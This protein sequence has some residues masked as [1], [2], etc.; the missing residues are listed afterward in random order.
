MMGRDV[1]IGAA[2]GLI[3]F[4]ICAETQACK[5]TGLNEEQATQVDDY[6]D[7]QFLCVNKSKTLEE[8]RAC[9]CEVKARYGRPCALPQK[10]GGL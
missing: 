2:L 3:A 5:S 8:S 1:L 6:V 9:R 10:D 4:G 7:E